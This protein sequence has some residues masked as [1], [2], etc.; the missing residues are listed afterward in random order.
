[1]WLMICGPT[2]SGKNVVAKELVKTSFDY[3]PSFYVETEESK[4]IQELEILTSRVSAQMK[5]STLID[6]R[7]IYTLRSFWDSKY[8]YIPAGKSFDRFSPMEA[9][10]LDIVCKSFDDDA[11]TPPT[12]VIY[13][14]TDKMNAHN[15]LALQNRG[16][17][18]S[19]EEFN[20]HVELYDKMIE[21]VR[22]PVIE[23]DVSK[24][25]AEIAKNLEFGLA[26]LKSANLTN[27]SVWS[28]TFFR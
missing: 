27:A 18:I 21:R 3:L 25:I 8:V 9:K 1:M 11:L 17:E 14:K 12:A 13:C 4:F 28:R 7:D 15:R 22:V 23:I 19:D 20:L 16:V 24:D 10:A 6:R 5:A 26:S 2:G